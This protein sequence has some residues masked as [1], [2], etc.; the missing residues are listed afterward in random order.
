MSKTDKQMLHDVIMVMIDHGIAD[1]QELTETPKKELVDMLDEVCDACD[2][3]N[4][5]LENK[6][7]IN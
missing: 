1:Y 6:V 3:Y 7:F 4:F 2:Y 5:A